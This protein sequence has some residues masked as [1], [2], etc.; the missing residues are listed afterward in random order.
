MA[1]QD[2]TNGHSVEQVD[3]HLNRRTADRAMS[4]PES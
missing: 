3:A 2:V 1:Q 4:D